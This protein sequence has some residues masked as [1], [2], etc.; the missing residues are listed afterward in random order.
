M[1]THSVEKYGDLY[2]D[3]AESYMAKKNYALAVGFLLPLIRSESY[4]QVTL[5]TSMIN[6]SAIFCI[7]S[8][9]LLFIS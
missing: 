1:V 2:L 9:Y 8:Y 4:S 5:P 7:L 6:W 3:I